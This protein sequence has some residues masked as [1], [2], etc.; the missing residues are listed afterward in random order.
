MLR[1]SILPIIPL[2]WVF[3]LLQFRIFGQNFLEKK[4]YNSFLTAQN[5]AMGQFPPPSDAATA[6]AVH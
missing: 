3:T 5:L 4:F 6:A 1:I 2:K